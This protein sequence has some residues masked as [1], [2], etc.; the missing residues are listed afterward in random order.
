[1]A[2]EVNTRHINSTKAGPKAHPQKRMPPPPPHP[3]V[4]SSG[5]IHKLLYTPCHYF[6]THSAAKSVQQGYFSKRLDSRVISVNDWT[7]NTFTGAHIGINVLLFFPLGFLL[8]PFCWRLC[9]LRSLLLCLL[10]C[11]LLSLQS[12]LQLTETHAGSA[13]EWKSLTHAEQQYKLHCN[14]DPVKLWDRQSY[15]VTWTL[16]SCGTG[17]Q[18]AR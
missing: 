15:T 16:S 9:L 10:L 2:T 4:C 5:I 8:V 7:S 3:P 13:T 14:L 17:R 18:D 11:L 1:M 6:Q 12:P